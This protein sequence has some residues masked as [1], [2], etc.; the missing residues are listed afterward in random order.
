MLYIGEKVGR[1]GS[2]V[3]VALDPLEGTTITAK[4][5]PNALAV[6]ALAA[7]GCFLN[8]PDVYMEKI[9]VGGG[10]PEGIV[11]LDTPPET[12]IG[13]LAE[14]LRRAPTDIAACILDRPRH[15]DLIAAV[16]RAGARIRLIPDGDIAG[17]IATSTP[18]TGIDVYMGIGG[19]PE[20]VLAAAA[21][22]CI[23][24]QMQGRLTFRNDDERGRA[25]RL[26]ITDLDRK[27]DLDD[28][29]HGDVI[30][31]ATGV[32]DGSMLAGVHRFADGAT[33]ETVLMRS[34]SGTVRWIRARHDYRRRPRTKPGRRRRRA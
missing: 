29:A 2:K 3:D 24:G 4:G 14:A 8:S 33:T 32:T 28:L 18:E 1:G 7:E 12:V 6:L 20:G 5:G 30:F 13:N 10:L 25:A 26:G 22:Q 9:A 23:G 34:R 16:R 19:A 17:V 11:D 31:A 15:A 27:Y 21:L